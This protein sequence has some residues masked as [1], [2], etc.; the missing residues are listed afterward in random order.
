ME[1]FER[2]SDNELK[3]MIN[4]LTSEIDNAGK[5]SELSKINETKN[6]ITSQLSAHILAKKV[7]SILLFVFIVRIFFSS[8]PIVTAAFSL[9]ILLRRNQ[10]EKSIDKLKNEYEKVSNEQDI[11]DANILLKCNELLAKETILEYRHGKEL[12]KNK[13]NN[14]NIFS[15]LI[16]E[17]QYDLQKINEK[18]NYSSSDLIIIPGDEGEFILKL[19]DENDK[20]IDSTYQK[21]LKR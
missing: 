17:F 18:Y 13:V 16:P 11:Y 9:F 5:F 7:Y 2:I 10:I 4:E 12:S 1:N 14:L 20:N 3:I 15:F 6:N 19:D 8:V 21:R